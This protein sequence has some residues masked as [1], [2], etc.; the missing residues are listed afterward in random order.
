LGGTFSIAMGV[1]AAG[2]AIGYSTIAGDAAAHAFSWTHSGGMID[3]GTLGGE[4]SI[5][6][7]V[8]AE[9]GHDPE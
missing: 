4:A 7:S 3:L 9:E 1:N 5:P 2:Q 6:E 8:N